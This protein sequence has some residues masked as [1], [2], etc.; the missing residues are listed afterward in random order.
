MDSPAPPPPSP[1]PKDKPEGGVPHEITG[2]STFTCSYNLYCRHDG[3]KKTLSTNKP[4]RKQAHVKFCCILFTEML[5]I[6]SIYVIY[7]QNTSIN[8][9]Q[10]YDSSTFSKDCSFYVAFCICMFKCFL[11]IRY[12]QNYLTFGAKVWFQMTGGFTIRTIDTQRHIPQWL[13][14]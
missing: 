4:A 8:I 1:E 13:C 7:Y 10:S 3:T 14:F 5:I 6:K 2:K 9:Q 12:C 11:A